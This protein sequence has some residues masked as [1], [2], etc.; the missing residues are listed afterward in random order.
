MSDSRAVFDVI[1]TGRGPAG[2][3]AALA[4]HDAGLK[5]ALIGPPINEADERT[6]ALLGPSIDALEGYRLSEGLAEIGTP[7]MT[8]RLLD[9]TRRL[10]RA[11]AISFEAGEIGRAAF[12]LNCPNA[13]L[14]AL[15]H[16]AVVDRP[17]IESFE[18]LVAGYDLSCETIKV[19]VG[20]G[21]VLHTTTVIAADGRNSPARQAAGIDVRRWSYPQTAAVGNVRHTKPHENISTEFHTET[22]PF[23]FVPLE[24]RD[25]RHRSSFVCALAPDDAAKVGKLSI[26]D[27][28]R[29][30]E[31][32]SQFLLGELELE[33]PVQLWPL[34]GLVAKAFA[35]NGVFLVGETAHAFPPI[36]AQGL[37]LSIRDAREA[38]S[39]IGEALKE[40]QNPRSML[41]ASRYSA[42]R[43][44]DVWAR[45]YG[46]DA[47]NRSLLTD[48]PA[49]Q[50][51]RAV[52]MT[53]ARMSPALKKGLMVA[54][55]EPFSLGG[56]IGRMADA[57]R[58]RAA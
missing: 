38:A 29:F 54:G 36:G 51:G 49:V 10:V 18:G 22:G 24:D 12:G 47:L 57:F 7:L 9:G 8:M 39:V 13:H 14:N 42:R 34:E 30:L 35:A 26:E 50:L 56:S 33:G 45:T 28:S 58:K 25:D 21:T 4:A 27:A 15:L 37:N 32:R 3:I 41:I 19:T 48:N 16:G 2:M 20:D 6:T 31:K 46:V 55:L 52:A 40:G 5:V 44:A 17:E 43:R 11:P 53:A 23:T 1:V